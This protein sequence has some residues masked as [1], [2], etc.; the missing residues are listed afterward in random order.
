[1]RIY[2]DATEPRWGIGLPTVNYI[3]IQGEALDD[4]TILCERVFMS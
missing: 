2:V 3:D 1:M 4:G